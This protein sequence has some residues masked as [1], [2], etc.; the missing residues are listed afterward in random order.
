MTKMSP[1]PLTSWLRIFK[2]SSAEKLMLTP[3]NGN[4]RSESSIRDIH[5]F[6]NMVMHLSECD[7]NY[8]VPNYRF[9]NNNFAFS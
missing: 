2:L 6:G 8:K 7:T 3:T 5:S 4:S 9:V 1:A